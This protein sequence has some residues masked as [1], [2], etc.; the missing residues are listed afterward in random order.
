MKNKI[1]LY[2][3]V[4]LSIVS[5][6]VAIWLFIDPPMRPTGEQRYEEMCAMCPAIRIIDIEEPVYSWPIAIASFSVSLAFASLLLHYKQV[7]RGKS[8]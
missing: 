3:L 4:I 1:L 6:I 8:I 7:K 2:V 5:G